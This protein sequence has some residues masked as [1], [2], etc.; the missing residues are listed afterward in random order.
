MEVGGRSLQLLSAS[1]LP[2]GARITVDLVDLPRASLGQKI[3]ARIADA[4]LELVAPVGLAAL[5]AAVIALALWRGRRATAGPA[6]RR[7][8]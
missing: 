1:G 3:G 4:P 2:R 5:M 8:L 6:E 7:S